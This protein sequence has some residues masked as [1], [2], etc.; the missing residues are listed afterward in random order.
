MAT[1]L[2][3]LPFKDVPIVETVTPEWRPGNV[4][5]HALISA[6]V[7]YAVHPKFLGTTFG[8]SLSIN[9]H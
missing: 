5:I 8:F 2:I 3:G 6:S 4:S 1:I 9:L 7:W